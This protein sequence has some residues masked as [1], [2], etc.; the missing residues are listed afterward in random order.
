MPSQ[1]V[2]RF[3][4]TISSHKIVLHKPSRHPSRTS[5]VH[6][7]RSG[8][9]DKSQKITALPTITITIFLNILW[10]LSRTTLLFL[11]V[12]FDQVNEILEDALFLFTTQRLVFPY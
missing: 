2:Q 12:P 4:L 3:L 9:I 1:P 5:S 7:L 6:R 8:L 11:L 10:F